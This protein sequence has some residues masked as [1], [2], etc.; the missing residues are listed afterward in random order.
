M[1]DN[2]KLLSEGVAFI[3]REDFLKKPKIK[4]V[5]VLKSAVMHREWSD[6]IFVRAFNSITGKIETTRIATDEA[7]EAIN[8]GEWVLITEEN[9]TII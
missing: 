1:N 2:Y 5:S 7:V 4:M 8:S 6:V 9:H 3:T